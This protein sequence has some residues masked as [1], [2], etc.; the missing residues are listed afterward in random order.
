MEHNMPK[1]QKISNH[2]IHAIK[3]GKLQPGMRTPSENDIMTTYL[4]SNTTAR[5]ALAQLELSG[6]ANRIK[7]KGTFVRERKVLRRA[8]KILS[9]TKNM[10][11]AGFSPSTKIITRVQLKQ[12]YGAVIG[13]RKYMM[14]G[15]VFFIKR[16]R[17]GDDIPM[18]LESRYISTALCPDLLQ[19]NLHA[20]LYDLYWKTYG[21]E[22]AEI[23][24]S[25]RPVLIDEETN[26]YFKEDIPAP[27]LA[28]DG[29]TFCGTEIILEMEHS[30]YRGDMYSFSVSA[31]VGGND[32]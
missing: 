28:I 27:A 8:N 17:F 21:L 19:A 23:R 24:Q 26:V 1:Y 22:L 20:S 29:V 25:L 7:G 2:I 3:E 15:P 11:E 5:K 16:L 9:F 32:T 30:I 10:L 18:L 12:G 14:P 13:G 4:V 6:W 31:T